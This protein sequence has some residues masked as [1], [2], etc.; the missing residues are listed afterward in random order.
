MKKL[1]V[2]V[3]ADHLE[4]MLNIRRP[5]V[6]LAELAWNSLD[7][8]ATTVVLDLKENGLGG[9]ERI[10]VEDDGHGIDYEEALRVFQ[11]LGGSWKRNQRRSR[12]GNRI[13]HGQAGEGRFRAFALGRTVTWESCFKASDGKLRIFSLSAMKEDLKSFSV[14]DPVEAPKGRQAGTTVTITDIDRN[15]PGLQSGKAIEEF[16]ELFALY[17]RNYRNI[18]LVFNGKNIEPLS[19]AS[20]VES[21]PLPPLTLDDGRQIKAELEIIE[22]WA[23]MER[24]LVLCDA[25]GFALSRQPPGIQAPG[26]NFTAYLKSDYVRELEVNQALHLEELHPG[27]RQLIDSAKQSMRDYFRK[28]SADKA[29]S[30]VEEWKKQNVYPYEG[31]P[32]NVIEQSERQVFDVCALNIHD[33]LPDFEKSDPLSKRL[34]LRLLRQAIEESPE[35][36]QRILRDVLDLPREKQTELAELLD[37]TTLSSIINAAKLVADRLEFLTGLEVLLYENRE[38]LREVDQLHRM[39]A[40]Q[41]WIF[42]E[43]FNLSVDDEGLT[44]VLRAHLDLTGRKDEVVLAPVLQPDGRRGRVDLMFSRRIPQQRAEEREHLIVELKRP[45]QSIDLTVAAQIQRYALAV[46]KDERFRDTTTRWGFWAISNDV[47]EMVRGMSRQRS[48]AR[49]LFYEDEHLPIRVWVKSWGELLEECRGRLTFFQDQLKYSADRDTALDYLR[50]THAKYLPT[51]LHEPA[52][53]GSVS[54]PG[55]ASPATAASAGAPAAATRP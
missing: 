27:L 1:T 19:L 32:K 30:V 39:L 47:D 4:R 55:T 28:R 26:F 14:S 12:S 13:L 11:N 21:N 42:G 33:Y 45:K 52:A 40:E 2:Q 41:T 38:E 31:Q 25:H 36:V 34:S 46:A 16:S 53:G 7:A 50:R 37:K 22:W 29:V 5:I 43:E 24:A 54:S 35:D 15:L 6:A 8:D 10:R 48:R 49:G 9:M 18:R 23:P 51:S 20:H 3:Q 44:R 17:L